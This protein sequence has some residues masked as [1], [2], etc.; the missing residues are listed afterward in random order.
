MVDDPCAIVLDYIVPS[1]FTVATLFA[2]IVTSYRERYNLTRNQDLW[3]DQEWLN[4]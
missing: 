3:R 1:I 4:R 2:I